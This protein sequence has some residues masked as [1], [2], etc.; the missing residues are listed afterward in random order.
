VVDTFATAFAE[1]RVVSDLPSPLLNTVRP[2]R[3]V[4]FERRDQCLN[5]Q[6]RSLPTASRAASSLYSS[7][8]GS[9]MPQR[10]RAYP[11]R[12]GPLG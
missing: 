3:S 9:A 4:S 7:S 11:A 5:C 12:E 6:S 8:A 10:L 1:R 2:M